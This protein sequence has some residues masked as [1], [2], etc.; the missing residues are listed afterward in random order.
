[1][2]NSLPDESVCADVGAVGDGARDGFNAFLGNFAGF[3]Q[4]VRNADNTDGA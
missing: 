2:L 4:C 1:M 3:F